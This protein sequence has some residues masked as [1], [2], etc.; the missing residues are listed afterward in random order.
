MREDYLDDVRWALS[1]LQRIETDLLSQAGDLEDF[2][3]GR[4]VSNYPLGLKFLR[5]VGLEIDEFRRQLEYRLT[6]LM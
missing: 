1:E 2:V 6:G 4:R 5:N 3:T